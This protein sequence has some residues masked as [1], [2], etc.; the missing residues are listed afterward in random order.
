[1]DIC[2]QCYNY[3]WEGGLP[4][5]LS[6]ALAVSTAKCETMALLFHTGGNGHVQIRSALLMCSKA[7]LCSCHEAS[8]SLLADLKSCPSLVGSGRTRPRAQ[9]CSPSLSTTDP[10]CH[11]CWHG[12]HEELSVTCQLG[13]HPGKT[14]S[15]GPG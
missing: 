3:F 4:A 15:G 8:P 13:A 6:G 1:M 12:G 7:A 2:S 9:H 11:H 5:S 10:P 14:C